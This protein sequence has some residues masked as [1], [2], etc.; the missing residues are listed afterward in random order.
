MTV[1]EELHRLVDELPELHAYELQG[2]LRELNATQVD[3]E[4][5]TAEDH[6]AIARGE[7]DLEAGRAVKL[8][9]LKRELS[10]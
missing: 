2:Y 1:K 8:D 7:A 5:L 9:D 6:Q 10:L 3:D 4:P